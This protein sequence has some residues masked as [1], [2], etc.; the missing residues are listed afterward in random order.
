M[1]VSQ[2]RMGRILLTALPLALACAVESPEPSPE[3]SDDVPCLAPGEVCRDEVCVIGG[4]YGDCINDA[5]AC[6][7]SDVAVCLTSDT[8]LT[9][10][11][12]VCSKVC[13]D[14]T[15]CWWALPDESHSASCMFSTVDGLSYC[16]IECVVSQCPFG[17]V[18]RSGICAF[19]SDGCGP[20]AS[21]D[22]EYCVCDP[23][24]QW[25]DPDPLVL[26]CCDIPGGDGSGGGGNGCCRTCTTGK[27]CGDTCIA[28]HLDCDQPPGCAC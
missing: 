25:C 1:I 19:D 28:S 12:G 9:S 7:A 22:G 21:P 18:C 27:P 11:F 17:M 8:T 6:G 4:V 3:C 10:G 13:D 24:T 2:R 26:D 5:A 20:T 14:E 15:D 23:G 16:V